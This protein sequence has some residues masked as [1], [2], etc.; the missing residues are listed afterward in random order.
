MATPSHAY[1]RPIV[2]AAVAAVVG[3][4]PTIRE[5]QAV[6]AVCYLETRYG[7][8]VSPDGVGKNNWGNYHWVDGRG[9]GRAIGYYQGKDATSRGVPYAQKFRA[10]ATPIDGA[11]DVAGFLNGCGA[12]RAAEQ[13]GNIW[14]VATSMR[15]GRYYGDQQTPD[16]PQ[17]ARYGGGLAAIVAEIARVCGDGSAGL[18]TVRTTSGG[19]LV[20]LAALAAA[21][22]LLWYAARGK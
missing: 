11:A 21:G 20:A 15:K 17:I 10:Y 9:N 4:T 3:R 8:A 22:G 14:E 19:S 7:T 5:V 16:E 6:Q 18:S 12:L 1:A 2:M 13:S